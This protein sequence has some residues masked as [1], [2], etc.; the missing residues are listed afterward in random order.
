RG[1][2]LVACEKSRDL[3]PGAEFRPDS[4]LPVLG[5]RKNSTARRI[6]AEMGCAAQ[7]PQRPN[8][9]GPLPI[10]DW[11]DLP[12]WEGMH[13]FWM[14]EIARALRGILPAGYRAVIGSSPLVTVGV[15]PVK[16]DVA[17]TNGS[18]RPNATPSAPVA[19]ALEP[20]VE[21]AVATLTEDATV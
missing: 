7:S 14:T 3:Q 2:C 12:G 15:A 1:A 17:V 20:D 21:I 16:P 9:G 10:H 18:Q 5:N 4:K 8:S 19:S 13:I 11:T 6:R